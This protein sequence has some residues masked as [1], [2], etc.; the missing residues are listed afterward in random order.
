MKKF[1]VLFLVGSSLFIL[2]ACGS[3]ETS[4]SAS[5]ANVKRE[6]NIDINDPSKVNV[7]ANQNPIPDNFD[8]TGGNRNVNSVKMEAPKRLSSPAADNSEIFTELND[9]PVET[10]VFKDHPK[11]IKIVKSGIPP[12]HT[13]KVYLK[14]GKVMDLPGEKI[15]NLATE[16]ASSVLTMLGIDAPAQA[17]PNRDA[18]KKAAETKKVETVQ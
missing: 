14:E 2:S 9:V 15:P 5:D 7:N 10:R 18:A 11:L 17:N 8:P 12:K 1:Y 6:A 16:P 3:S 4:R 13:I